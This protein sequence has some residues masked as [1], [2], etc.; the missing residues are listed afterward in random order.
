VS[1]YICVTKGG[2][3]RKKE[4][5]GGQGKKREE[6]GRRGKKREEEGGRGNS[7]FLEG[8]GWS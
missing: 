1:E 7:I 6:E 3:R 2:S 8:V 4:E 5:E